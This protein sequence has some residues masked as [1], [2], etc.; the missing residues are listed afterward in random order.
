MNKWQEQKDLS[1]PLLTGTPQSHHF[2]ER[3][4]VKRLTLYQ[5]RSPTTKAIKMEPHKMV[6]QTS[7]YC[8]VLYPWG[9][10]FTNRR[11]TGAEAL[12]KEVG[13]LA[14]HQ[15]QPRDPDHKDKPSEH[16]AL[17]ASNA[18]NWESHRAG[19]IATSLSHVQ[20]KSRNRKSW[21]RLTYWFWSLLEK[22]GATAT[23]PGDIETGVIAILG[24]SFLPR[25]LVL[26]N[27]IEESPLSGLSARKCSPTSGSNIYRCCPRTHDGKQQL[28]MN[29]AHPPIDRL[30]LEPPPE[31]TAAPGHGPAH[32]RAQGLSLHTIVE[33]P[34]PRLPA[35]TWDQALPTSGQAPALESPG[36]WSCPSVSLF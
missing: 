25:T 17:K 8:P 29:T 5:S 24:S 22:Q 19:E 23:P 6:G 13:H 1:S 10:H 35:R 32:Q 11:I 21:V 9:G 2:L 30:P 4:S 33:V 3:P 18:Y 36:P 14:P 34:D 20:G 27:A 31:T 7:W 16:L 28:G 12:S 26:A 15:T